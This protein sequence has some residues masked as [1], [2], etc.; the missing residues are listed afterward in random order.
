MNIIAMRRRAFL[1]TALLAFSA[2]PIAGCGFRLRQTPVF[3]FKTIRLDMPTTALQKQLARDLRAMKQVTIVTD[4]TKAEVTLVSSGEQRD[5]AVLSLTATGE[6]R[7][8]QLLLRFSFRVTGAS[9]EDLVPQTEILRR[10]NQSYSDT[11][12]LSKGTEAEILYKNMQDDVVQQVMRRLVRV[13]PDS[14]APAKQQ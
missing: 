7:E 8:Y 6:A 2:L 12:A 5:R 11:D 13:K 1:S 4:P 3:E 9:G 14:S 10:I